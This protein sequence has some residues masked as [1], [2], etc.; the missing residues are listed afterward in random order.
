M[1][2]RDDWYRSAAW[3]EGAREEFEARIARARSGRAQYLLI[4]GAV[5]S[6][7]DD[8]ELRETGRGLM[9]RS[10][11]DHPDEV[12]TVIRIHHAVAGAYAKDGMHAEASEHY[13]AAL[14][15]EDDGISVIT[16]SD[17]ELAELIVEAGWQG[18]YE[19]ARS[20]LDHF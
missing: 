9:T 19:E 17:L 15:M 6:A 12:V 7:S 5:L 8:P 10:L 2:T 14:K 1:M 4:K 20:W 3:D 13:E 18:R 16:R 11:E